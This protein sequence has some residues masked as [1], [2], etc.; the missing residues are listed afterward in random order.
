MPADKNDNPCQKEFRELLESFLR[1]SKKF[2]QILTNF[3]KILYTLK[4]FEDQYQHQQQQDQD[5]DQQQ[6]KQ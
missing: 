2:S 6:H 3:Y 4:N 1:T 5:Q